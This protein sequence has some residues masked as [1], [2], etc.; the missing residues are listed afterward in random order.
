[1]PSVLYPLIVPLSSKVMVLTAP[2]IFA[3][4]SISSQNSITACL[5]GIVIDNPPK[6]IARAP[7]SASRKFSGGTPKAR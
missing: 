3:A 1:M 7:S 6:P 4:G 2:I 5:C